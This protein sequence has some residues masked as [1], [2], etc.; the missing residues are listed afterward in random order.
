[1]N[2]RKH[3]ERSRERMKAYASGGSVGDADSALSSKMRSEQESA[4]WADSNK[5]QGPTP[6]NLRTKQWN[7]AVDGPDFA[8]RR[9]RASGRYNYQK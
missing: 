3:A 4:G 7:D 1:M 9:A 5:G 6:A 2:H 8:D